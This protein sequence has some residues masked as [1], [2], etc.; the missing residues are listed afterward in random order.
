MQTRPCVACGQ[1]IPETASLCSVCRSYQKS[2]K[3]H[4]QYFSSLAALIAV[5]F[6][7]ITWLWANARPLIWY[8]DDVRLVAMNSLGSAVVLNR[9]DGEIFLS[10]LLLNIRGRSDTWHVRGLEF[11]EQ[12]SPGQFVRKEFPKPKIGG[13]DFVRGMRDA[14]FEN[15]VSEAA[16]GTPCS[17]L[18]FL[19]ANDSSC[20]TSV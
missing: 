6:A 19:G 18:V 16:N 2:W 1:D 9:S 5:I 10:H 7:S 4:A 13:G 17:E 14:E 20:A 15:L 11:G 8:R 12:V 3:N